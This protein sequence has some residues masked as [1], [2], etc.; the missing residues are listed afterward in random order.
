MAQL[1][2]L[3][4][5]ARQTFRTILGGQNVRVRAWWQPLDENWYISLSNLD[6]TPIITGLRL[7]EAARPVDGHLLDFKGG[8]LIDGVGE[9]GRNAWTTTHRLVYLTEVEAVDHAV[10]RAAAPD[11]TAG[12]P[13]KPSAF[14]ITQGDAQA[15]L[16]FRAGNQGSS[17]L[18]GWQYRFR[19][20]GDYGDW[21][22]IPGGAAATNHIVTGL[23]NGTPY[24]FQVRTVSDQGWSEPSNA[25]AVRPTP[26]PAAPATFTATPGNAMVTLE[27]TAAAGTLGILRWEYRLGVTGSD[28]PWTAIPDSASASIEHVV[29]GLQNNTLHT[30][31]VRIINRTGVGAI[32]QAQTFTPQP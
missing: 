5:D 9:V 31:V 21:I 23:T 1:I 29:T 14:F 8:L 7:D 10:R 19:T 12:Y 6:G 18:T 15:E 16:L 17:A 2:A 28:P 32:S 13:G 25:M 22:D 24:T 4:D 27:G 20:T 26:R 3:T 11:V 30:V